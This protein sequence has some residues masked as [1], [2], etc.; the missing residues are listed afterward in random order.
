[1]K[2][3]HRIT[4]ALLLLAGQQL[5]GQINAH[6]SVSSMAD[7][8][9][10]NNAQN[11]KSNVTSFMFTGGYDW[12]AE[13]TL[14]RLFY[15]GTF[16]YYESLLE[17]TNHQHSVTAE[18]TQ[19]YGDDDQHSIQA[20][21]FIGTAI[22]R[23]AYTLFDHS[24]L[25]VFINSKYFLSDRLI[26]KTGYTLRSVSFS[27]L[28]D[29]SYTEHALFGQL[30][31]AAVP[32]TTIIVQADLGS[33]FYSTTPSMSSASM[34]KGVMSSLMPSVTQTIGTV[35][36]GQGITDNI[37]ISI[38]ERYQLNLQKQTRYLSSEYGFISDD[39]LFDDHYGYEGLHSNATVTAL[40]SETTT[41]K[42]SGGIQNKLYSSLAAFDVNGN[43][44]AGQ[45]SDERSYLNITLLKRFDEQG[46]SVKG[47][48]DR[49][50]NSSNDALYHYNNTAVTLELGIPF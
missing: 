39:E 21:G 1:M 45:R 31:F 9:V 5:F 15:D 32:T 2:Q 50:Q 46:I 37:G 19:W 4:L 40:L 22:N 48:I 41:L 44:A 7:D 24:M 27:V 29:F 33:K 11:L 18:F 25:S 16:T 12:E 13:K 42:V 49:I 23:D 36:I 14:T 20:G 17:R 34:R 26:N 47:S 30:A 35:K 3:L 10:N 28:D 6:A 43:Y 8:N 38:T